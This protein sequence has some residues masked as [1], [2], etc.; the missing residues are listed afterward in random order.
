LS[1]NIDVVGE[2]RVGVGAGMWAEEA[3]AADAMGVEEA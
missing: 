2:W 1:S 3:E